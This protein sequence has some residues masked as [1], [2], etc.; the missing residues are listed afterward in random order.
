LEGYDNIYGPDNFVEE[1]CEHV[2]NL[3]SSRVFQ[4]PSSIPQ[5]AKQYVA[6]LYRSLAQLDEMGTATTRLKGFEKL[7]GTGGIYSA[8]YPNTGKNP[9][10]LYFFIQGAKVVLLTPFLEK[11]SGDY[12]RAIR[13]AKARK[14][15][16]KTQW[17]L[18]E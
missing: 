15:T 11:N 16:F 3:P 14:A 13:V 5:E 18:D 1:F 9:R 2:L 8:R 4:N 10:I 17:P 6:W 12:Q 7:P